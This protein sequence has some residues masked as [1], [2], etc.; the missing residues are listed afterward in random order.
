MIALLSNSNSQPWAIVCVS[1]ALVAIVVGFWVS[2]LMRSVDATV[3]SLPI[4]LVGGVR[5]WLLGTCVVAIVATKMLLGPN[6]FA[7]IGQNGETQLI[8]KVRGIGIQTVLAGFAFI[9][10]ELAYV[11][12]LQWRSG[13]R[14]WRASIWLIVPFCFLIAFML[15]DIGLFVPMV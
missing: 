8:W 7:M 5:L 2:T 11:G 3:A 9:P 12:L 14:L 1:A 6:A 10:L 13:L 15:M 4:A